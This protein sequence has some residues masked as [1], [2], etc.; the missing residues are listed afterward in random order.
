[1][2]NART[3]Q[4][5]LFIRPPQVVNANRFPGWLDPQT[6]TWVTTLAFLTKPLR[7]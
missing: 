6:N 2:V 7:A 1:M 3:G 4:T 5:D